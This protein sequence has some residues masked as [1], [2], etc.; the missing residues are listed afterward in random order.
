M[1]EEEFACCLGGRAFGTVEEGE[2]EGEEDGDVQ[3]GDG[4]EDEAW[5]GSFPLWHLGQY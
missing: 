1:M 4:G 3:E 2:G 5:W